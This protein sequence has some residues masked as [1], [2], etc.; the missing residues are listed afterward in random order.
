[1]RSPKKKSQEVFHEAVPAKNAFSLKV[2][3][4]PEKSWAPTIQFDKFAALPELQ[5]YADA[6]RKATGMPFL[7]LVPPEELKSCIVFDNGANPLCFIVRSSQIGCRECLKSQRSLLKKANAAQEVRHKHCFVGLNA[8]AVPVMDGK[9]HLGT[10]VSGQVFLRQPSEHDFEKVSEIFS[11]EKG[12]QW[13]DRARKVYFETPVVPEEKLQA[14]VQLLSY[15]AR[16]LP[17]DA[18]R[19][20]KASLPFEHE[21]VKDAKNFIESSS[22]GSVSPDQVFRHIRV[23]RFYFCKIFK[24]ATGVTL[25]EYLVRFRL[26]KAKTLLLDP[27][28]RVSDVVFASGFGSIAQFNSVFK[29]VVGMSP[30]EYRNHCR[31]L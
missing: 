10:L 31:T 15:F 2:A 22:D 20:S 7:K 8:F 28:L 21:A 17:D 1:M 12:R 23:S 25:T 9:K 4:A 14:A 6:F 5:E 13:L 24:E 18:L 3:N 19:S 29:R 11:K 26:T 30:T 27:N 16:H